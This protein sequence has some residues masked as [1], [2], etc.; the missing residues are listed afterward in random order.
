M[1][2]FRQLTVRTKRLRLVLSRLEPYGILKVF[3]RLSKSCRRT[4]FN[5]FKRPSKRKRRRL[6]LCPRLRNFLPRKDS[7][8]Q[9]RS[10]R[11]YGLAWLMD[12]ETF[13][14]LALGNE[15]ARKVVSFNGLVTFRASILS[16]MK[17]EVYTL[18]TSNYEPALSKIRANQPACAKQSAISKAKTKARPPPAA[19][20]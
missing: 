12:V 14:G 15:D 1:I 19:Q 20:L 11:G 3:A 17:E 16:K 2:L 5:H 8:Q 7:S 13:A 9:L 6:R 4:A 18:L 10:R